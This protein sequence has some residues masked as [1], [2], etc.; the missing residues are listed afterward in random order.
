MPQDS[1]GPVR[2]EWIKT[3][4]EMYRIDEP[5]AWLDLNSLEKRQEW[6]CENA[7]ICSEMTEMGEDWYEERPL[8]VPV[9]GH[10]LILPS[11]RAVEHFK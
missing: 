10:E 2:G 11:H 4:P 9:V 5:F 6:K 3:M 1:I 8:T 7:A